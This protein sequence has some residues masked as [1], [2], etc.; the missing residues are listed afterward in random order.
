[1]SYNRKSEQILLSFRTENYGTHP[2]AVVIRDDLS[3]MTDYFF[4]I[5]R[6]CLTVLIRSGHAQ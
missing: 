3:G 2:P 5:R 4:F 6:Y 1:M